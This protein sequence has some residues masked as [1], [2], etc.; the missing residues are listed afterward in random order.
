MSSSERAALQ[1]RLSAFSRCL[2]GRDLIATSWRLRLRVRLNCRALLALWLPS[3]LRSQALERVG[4]RVFPSADL[5]S[6][7]KLKR[8]TQRVRSAYRHSSLAFASDIRRRNAAAMGPATSNSL[9]R[10]IARS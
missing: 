3:P 4:G 8:S 9:W 10:S 6:W 5:L 7:Q 2:H 1:L